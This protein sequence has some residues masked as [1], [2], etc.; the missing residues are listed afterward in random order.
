MQARRDLLIEGRVATE[1]RYQQQPDAPIALS[2]LRTDLEQRLRLL[3]QRYGITARSLTKVVRELQNRKILTED[4]A[5]AILRLVHYG[6]EAAHG[7]GRFGSAV[8]RSIRTEAPI[9]L[10]RLDALIDAAP[11]GG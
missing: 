2:S 3:A 8:L 9:V 6:S 10:S 7:Q 11:R 1:R 4:S 5:D